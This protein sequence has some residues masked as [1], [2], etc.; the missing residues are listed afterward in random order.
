M[1]WWAYLQLILFTWTSLSCCTVRVGLAHRATTGGGCSCAD[2]CGGGDCDGSGVANLYKLGYL[3][4]PNF[5]LAAATF[6]FSFLSVRAV[7]FCVCVL[8]PFPFIFFVLFPFPF[9]SYISITILIIR[10][11]TY[12]RGIIVYGHS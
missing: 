8:F 9:I 5:F 7:L 4:F 12:S 11:D 2:D 6:A 1:L 10:V 3:F